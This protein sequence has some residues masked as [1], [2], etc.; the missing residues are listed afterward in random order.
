M[1]NRF[2]ALTQQL[3]QKSIADC[4]VE[5]LENLANDY[6]YFAPAQYILLAKLKDADNNGYQAQLQKAILYYH[7]PIVFDHFL[8]KEDYDVDFTS[9]EVPKILPAENRIEVLPE[10]EIQ[11]DTREE[12]LSEIQ[13]PELSNEIQTEPSD[14]IKEEGEIIIENPPVEEL[15]HEEIKNEAAS[16]AAITE[17]IEIIP[18]ITAET[19]Q[20]GT[21]LVFEPYHTV[22]YFASQGIKLSQEE[23]SKDK[24]GKQLKSFTEWL[25]TM[26]RLPAAEQVKSL[27]P[28]S[29]Q[30]IENLA[31]HSVEGEEVYTETMAEVWERQGNREK[32]ME[33]YNKLSLLNPSKRAYFAAKIDSL[34]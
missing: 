18:P 28:G 3:F 6:P 16:N 1:T 2:D 21:G 17:R 9:L 14:E 25:K 12:N 31:A 15:L 5:E 10:Q 27:E 7:D 34:K 33:V 24:F 19:N 8:N 4:S 20:T 22:D 32:A 26:K 13:E 11:K 23:V 30:K 29:E